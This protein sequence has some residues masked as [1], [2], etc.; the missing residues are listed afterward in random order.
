MME[1]VIASVAKEQRPVEAGVGTVRA[2][3]PAA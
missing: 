1:R 2:S 3:F